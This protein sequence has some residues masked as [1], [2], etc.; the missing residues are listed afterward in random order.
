ME[1]TES[2][3]QYLGH[4]TIQDFINFSKLLSDPRY[5]ILKSNTIDVV[6]IILL[7]A[8]RNNEL[9][10]DVVAWG[11]HSKVASKATFSRRKDFLE[12]I[13]LLYEES[14]KTPYGRPKIR[15]K[16]NEERFKD[17][18]KIESITPN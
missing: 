10:Y 2:M 12:K 5:T 15:L 18:F 9:F 1:P 13:G 16:L 17:V 6:A 7:A 11:E 4:N 14:V 3:P 8:A